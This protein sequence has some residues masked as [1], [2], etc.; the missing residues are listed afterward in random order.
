MSLNSHQIVLYVRICI[1]VA[2]RKK[3]S[4]IFMFK[5]YIEGQRVGGSSI[6]IIIV[7]V[8]YEY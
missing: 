3:Y 2:M 7:K 6:M 5:L 1:R 8:I 4:I